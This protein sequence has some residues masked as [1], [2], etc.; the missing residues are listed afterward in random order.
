[1]RPVKDQRIGVEKHAGVP[2]CSV[3]RRRIFVCFLPRSPWQSVLCPV[4]QL[5]LGFGHRRH[6]PKEN[7][8]RE[9]ESQITVWGFWYGWDWAL[10]T[11]QH[12]RLHKGMTEEQYL[13]AWFGASSS[14]PAIMNVLSLWPIGTMFLIL[15]VVVQKNQHRLGEESI[16]LQGWSSCGEAEVR[17]KTT[18]LWRDCCGIYQPEWSYTPQLLTY[19]PQDLMLIKSCLTQ[20][21]RSLI[22]HKF[23]NF[24]FKF[25][26]FSFL[27]GLE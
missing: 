15:L 19:L 1:M 16:K 23:G 10:S 17:W 4:K 14:K 9:G 11:I 5:I 18:L 2:P 27:T 20:H 6:I 3:S 21:L 7:C 25:G 13:R 8:C 22:S 26:T 12:S 24:S